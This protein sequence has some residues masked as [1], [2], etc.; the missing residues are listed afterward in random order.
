MKT[1]GNYPNVIYR[2][3]DKYEYAK[4]YNVPIKTN[5]LI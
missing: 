2:V 4:D 1:I 5:H 3:F